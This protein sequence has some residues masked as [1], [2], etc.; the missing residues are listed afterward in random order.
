MKK[1]GF[2][3]WHSQVRVGKI[4]AWNYGKPLPLSVEDTDGLTLFKAAV[5]VPTKLNVKILS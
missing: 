4:S 1:V 2:T 3:A 5:Y